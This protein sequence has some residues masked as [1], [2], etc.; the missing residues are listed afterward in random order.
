MPQSSRAS[1]GAG[2]RHVQL[3]Q[4]R[5]SDC[6]DQPGAVHMLSQKGRHRFPVDCNA[7]DTS[8][9]LRRGIRKEFS[10]MLSRRLLAGSAAALVCIAAV[11]ASVSLRHIDPRQRAAAVPG[12]AQLLAYGG[13]TLQQRA[14][15]PGR[16]DAALAGI[17]AHATNFSSATALADL[18]ALNPAAR[19]R[20][21]A[22]G[23]APEVAID[24]ATLGDARQLESALVTLGLEHPAV[25]A[26]SVGGWLPVSAITAAAVRPEVAYI[27]ASLPHRRG[28]VAT[29][30]DYVQ[31]S[32]AVR[33]AYPSLTGSGVTVGV[34]SDSFD[35]YAVY[36]AAG[37]GVP[38]SGLNGYASNGFTATAE[39]DE[40]SGALPAASAINVLA[41][42]YT[43][44][45]SDSATGDC[46]AYGAP[47]QLPFS[48]EGRAMLQVVH[49]VA[50]GANLAFYTGDNS[51]TDFATGITTLASPV[52][53]GG[54]GAKVIADD[55]GYFD[56]PFYQD[57]IVAQAIDTVAAAGVAYFSAAGNDANA[58][59]ESTA[60]S[61]PVLQPTTASNNAGEYL[62]NFDTTGATT[63]TALPIT[64]SPLAP[65]QYL[66]IVVEWDQPYVTGG[67]SG[68]TSQIDICVTGATTGVIVQDYDGNNVTCTGLNATGADPVQILI[69]GNSAAA[70]GNT[71]TQNLSFFVGT[72]SQS[73]APHRLIV[74][75]ETDGQTSPAP[76]S[77][78]S[79]NSETIQGHPNAAGAAAVAAAFYFDTPQC[80]TAPA[81]LEPYSS[82]GGAPILFS[83]S[84]TRLAT[85][86]LRQKPNFVGPD[87]VNN[88]FLGFTLASQ[89]ITGSNGLLS[90]NDSQCQ[91][92]PSYP[93]FF[94]T[95]AATPHAAGIAAL[96][97]QAV[98]ALSPTQIYTAL[99]KSA[100][101]IGTVPTGSTY[102][103]NAG[104]GFIQ[105]DAA[106]ATPTLSLSQNLIAVG[107]TT[108]LTWSTIEASS[109]TASGAWT[110]AEAVN[111]SLSITP[112]ASGIVTYTLTCTSATG[113]TGTASV[114][115]DVATVPPAPSLS[116][117][118]TSVPEGG[119]TVLTWSSSFATT[120]TA[121]GNGWSNGTV[122][123]SGAQQFKASS[124]TT[125]TFTLYCSNG[126]GPSPASSV[127]FTVTAPPP[128]A[129]TLTLSA[130]SITVG[131]SATLTWSDSGATACTASGTGWSGAKASSGSATETPTAAGTY[132]YTLMCANANGNSAAT[133]V[134]LDVTEPA[135]TATLS[136]SASSIVVGSTA[137]LSWVST[138]ATSCTAAGSWSGALATSGS[139]TVTPTATGTDT[140]TLVC[141]NG[142]VNSSTSSVTLSV[143]AKS[144]GGG[145]GALDGLSLLLLGGLTAAARRRSGQGP[146][147]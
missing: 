85:P 133:T 123:T 60:P 14:G 71:P 95:S 113:A 146:V 141:S 121:G 62:L 104:Y 4:M 72:S 126:F 42:P 135:P 3:D 142:T 145:G 46:L 8:V 111:G 55:L 40:A 59:W 1:A 122:A 52:S 5:K 94:G 65:G 16:V 26:N 79:T 15:M 125:Q 32:H 27:H 29:Q 97:L 107:A 54:A 114:L 53:A 2:K 108:T 34:L 10:G 112:T 70:T 83:S 37:S 124:L 117:S 25:F 91:N 41:E 45:G 93:N 119:S 20:A 48:D 143:T 118:S 22:S 147:A 76:I 17:A 39:D 106:L 77:S 74:S 58:S 87:G 140:Y 44:S 109:C 11:A 127:S 7:E 19:F 80:G 102:N 69:I 86:E 75:V 18:R 128:P 64:L 47:T 24:A 132:A 92:D 116:L 98:P 66:A 6:K 35:C 103:F 110:G 129:P 139:E 81:E 78:Y 12:K 23:K 61:F 144:S 31:H 134:T 120:C 73:T 33:Q 56:E 130:N 68:A 88:T 82:Q 21:S 57:G 49:A 63:A 84:G 67:G 96:M 99:E 137:T 89:N 101:A 36:A 115:L 38:A 9:K 105:A 30:G 90:T 131:A 50:P 43:P 138:N 51:E 13:R 100:L 136:E 28:I